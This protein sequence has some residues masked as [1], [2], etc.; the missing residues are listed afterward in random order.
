MNP[1]TKKKLDYNFQSVMA[2]TL[3]ENTQMVYESIVNK[4]AHFKPQITED[5]LN[6]LKARFPDEK[7]DEKP[8]PLE[9]PAEPKEDKPADTPEAKPA[10][11][12]EEKPAEPTE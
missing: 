8:E 10:E 2:M 1:F 12:P 7:W 11:T 3:Y 6:W 9:K 4:M 5:T